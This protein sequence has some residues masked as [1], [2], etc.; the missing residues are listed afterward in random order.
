MKNFK[1]V[2]LAAVILFASCGNPL[3]PEPFVPGGDGSLTGAMMSIS[4]T[5]GEKGSITLSWEPVSGPGVTYRLFRA[6]DQN[7]LMHMSTPVWEGAP[8]QFTDT[9]V[10]PGD[11]FFYRVQS[12]LAHSIL[13][14]SYPVEGTSLAKP[15]INGAVISADSVEIVWYISGDVSAYKDDLMYIVS[16]Y[17][18]AALKDWKKGTAYDFPGN[19]HIFYGLHA[20]TDYIFEV[21]AFLKDREE[22][23]EIDKKNEATLRLFEPQPPINLTATQGTFAG[24][25]ELT[26]NL[27]QEIS[28]SVEGVYEQRSLYFQISKRPLGT[29]DDFTLVCGYFGT[30][31]EKAKKA[32]KGSTFA[33]VYTHGTQVKWIDD[34]PA[35]GQI[36]EYQVQSFAEG[37]PVQY[38][39]SKRNCEGWAMAGGNI[40][41]GETEYELSEDGAFYTNAALPFTFSFDPN[42]INYAY[43]VITDVKGLRDG[44]ENDPLDFKL[45]KYLNGHQKVSYDKIEMNLAGKSTA[46]NLGRGVY[47]VEIEVYLNGS[48]IDTFRPL[49][50]V[51]ISE[52]TQRIEVNNFSIKDGYTDRFILRWDNYLNRRYTIE[53][54]NDGI[55]W[56]HLAYVNQNPDDDSE[57]VIKNYERSFTGY[58]L[59]QTRYFRI[60]PQ[61]RL[62]N[63]DFLS[64]Q[65]VLSTAVQTLGRPVLSINGGASYS[66]IT[67]IWTEAQKANAYRI[68]HR[69][70]GD[71]IWRWE[72][73]ESL[74]PDANRNFRYS[75]RPHDYNNPQKAGREI[76][77][78][79]EALNTSAGSSVPSA[80]V[81]ARLVGPALLDTSASR[82]TS[83]DE[84]TVSWSAVSGAGGY[85]VFRRQFDMTNTAQQ[86]VS[87]VYYIPASADSITG[88]NLANNAQN[89]IINT[90]IVSAKIELNNSRYT[91]RDLYLKDSDYSSEA[92]GRH[93]PAYR[94]QQNDMGQG[95]PYRY[96]VVP[97]IV[98]ENVPEPLNSISLVFDKA[99]GSDVNTGVTSY[100]MRENGT[101]ITYSGVA[102]FEHEGFAIGFGQNVNAA[103]GTYSSSGAGLRT[104]DGILITWNPPS[105]LPAEGLRYTVF[106]RQ[107]G[108]SGAWTTVISN[109]DS[110]QHID[111]PSDQLVRGQAYEYAVGISRQGSAY[112][113]PQESARFIDNAERRNERLGYMLSMV[114]MHSVSRNELRDAQNNFAEEVKWYNAGINNPYEN[115]NLN[116]GIDG[117]DVFVMNRNINGNW[118]RIADVKNLENQ[119]EQNVRVSNELAGDTLQGGLL[120]VLRDYKHFF[121]VRSYVEHDGEKVYSPDPEW[122]YQ[123]RFG[124]NQAAHITA[125]NNM[126]NDFVKWGARQ[127]TADEF[128]KISTLYM[129]RGLDRA[130]GTAWNTGF[131]GTRWGSASTTYGGSGRTGASSNF[132]VTSWDI[133]FEN[134]KDDYWTRAGDCLTFI[135]INGKLWAGTGASNQ[136]PQRYGD[137]GW[138]NIIGPWDT[139]NLYNGRIIVGTQGDTDL[140]WNGNLSGNTIRSRIAV[141]YPSGTARQNIPYRGMDTPLPFSGQGNNRHEQDAWK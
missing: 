21:K 66:V 136:Y 40:T 5:Q 103:K 51:E 119:S 33:S 112:S 105:R 60:T 31:N 115:G 90:N 61:R 121:K 86:G 3:I 47:T 133:T 80:N 6:S 104:N 117:Y 56:T 108:G 20:N 97:V 18:G 58:T 71:A 25:V 140:Y 68:G 123:Y 13:A 30:N 1:Y 29:Q 32:E 38:E 67:A 124:T 11:S 98:R 87:V 64:G 91:L 43:K 131:F 63:G 36:F 82:G 125:S 132:G 42:G 78:V 2:F 128:I 118:H 41:F 81:A 89:V 70:A 129:A 100:T 50:P 17:D 110:R 99:P 83:L 12:V 77:I 54:S 52:Q 79:V 75:F 94:N 23:Y 127:I 59:G 141:E 19:K 26:F 55:V 120:K 106:R 137:A 130:N 28:F 8:V 65:L 15:E 107:A 22:S 53:E 74:T 93:I 76:E 62:A 39:A 69:Y 138:I 46:L 102:S 7:T 73:L 139:P 101:N 57:A 48:L 116:W 27:P 85:Y 10:Q 14:E 95:I 37:S 24:K 111:N 16:C 122:T 109:I 134:Y 35:R 88:M 96:F 34:K 45:E 126:E 72:L 113:Q 9:D 114:R 84:I 92:Y 4:A 44:N 49:N 135:T